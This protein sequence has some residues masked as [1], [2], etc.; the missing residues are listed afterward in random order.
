MSEKVS[1]AVSRGEGNKQVSVTFSGELTKVQWE[2]FLQG[3]E[4]IA[5]TSNVTINEFSGPRARRPPAPP[6]GR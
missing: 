2:A 3:L 1:G 5:R 6:A 4:Q